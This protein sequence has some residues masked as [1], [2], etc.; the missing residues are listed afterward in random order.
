MIDITRKKIKDC[1]LGKYGA[2][3]ENDFLA[4]CFSSDENAEK[5][6]SVREEL[7]ET[8]LRGKLTEPERV[9]FREHFLADAEN[10]EA[11]YFAQSVRAQLAA[12]RQLA[13][14]VA[15]ARPEKKPL[16]FVRLLAPAGALGILLAAF[17][18]IWRFTGHESGPPVARTE[19]TPEILQPSPVPVSS[20]LP[21]NS[22]PSPEPSATGKPVETPKET[23][24]PTPAV[25]IPEPRTVIGFFM[26]VS[27]GSGPQKI[28]EIG[29]QA[30]SVDLFSDPPSKYAAY[31]IRLQKGE[32]PVWSVKL[33]NF[34]VNKE[35]LIVVRVPAEIF[36][37]GEYKFSIQGVK[38]DGTLKELPGATRSFQ[39]KREN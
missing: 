36:K 7:I 13:V 16:H 4:E 8:Y 21:V 31:E 5:F 22:R 17:L 3:E 1:L 23:V 2:D 9:Q 25:K 26:T 15:A 11:F 29:R 39:V 19:P 20:P 32:E 33:E 12:D 30:Q 18:L 24:T 38:E 27:K 14:A 6:E 34:K 10:S 35:G 28:L 37:D